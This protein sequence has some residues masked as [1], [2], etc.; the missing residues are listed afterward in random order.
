M[1]MM[2]GTDYISSGYGGIPNLDNVFAGSN[3]DCDDYDDYYTLQRDMQVD[4]GIIP[5]KEET[6]IEVRNKA[7]RAMQAVFEGLGLPEIT[8]EEVEAATY[9]YCYKDMPARNKVEDM[10]AATEMME[11]GTTVIDIIKIL[12]DA[13]FEDIAENLLNQMKQRVIG[14]YLHTSAIFDENYN[15]ISAVNDRNDYMGPGT[16]YRISENRWNVLKEK[17]SA[18]KTQEI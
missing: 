11:K 10:K 5:I 7:A 4:G 13:G 17:F 6:A 12:H 18:L 15:V 1:T 9:A 3:E 8:D 2:P 14:D 16:G